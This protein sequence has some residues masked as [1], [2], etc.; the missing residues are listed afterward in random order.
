MFDRLLGVIRQFDVPLF[1]SALVL[2][3]IGFL[4][5][6]SVDLSRGEVLTLLPTQALAAMIGI[7]GMLGLS[8]IHSS[9]YERRARV[10]YAAG[11]ILLV[12]V[13]FFGVTIRGTTGWFRLGGFS[14]QPAEVAK[15]G[16]IVILSLLIYKWAHAYTNIRFFVAGVFLVLLPVLLILLQPDLGSALVLLGIWFGMFVF[17]GIPWKYTATILVAVVVSSILAWMFVLAPYQKQRIYTFIDPSIDPLGSGYNVTQSIIAIGS[18]GVFGRGLGFGSQS[19]LHFLPEA[20][21]DF[22]F[23]V[24]AEELGLFGAAILLM[25]YL[26]MLLRLLRIAYQ[27]RSEFGAYLV[28]GIAI[29]FFIQIVFNVGASTGLLPLTGVTLP[30]VSYGGTSLIIN[31]FLIGMAQSVMRSYGDTKK[32]LWA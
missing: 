11:L 23:A 25:V 18:G 20:Q 2:L 27:S 7:S 6:Y 8:F 5:V 16:L 9:V 12:L 32:Q 10:I 14:F 29:L 30:F 26:T 15:I 17:A 4:S 1:L 28:A 3:A 31:L 19:Q 22:I 21:T 24:V 13:L